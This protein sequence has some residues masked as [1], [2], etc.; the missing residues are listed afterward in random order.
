MVIVTDVVGMDARRRMY[1]SSAGRSS[2]GLLEPFWYMIV[3][4]N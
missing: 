1:V 4:L 2:K 3:S